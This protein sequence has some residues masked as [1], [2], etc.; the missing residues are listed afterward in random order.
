VRLLTNRSFGQSDRSS[1][2]V[3]KNTKIV[4][5][6]EIRDVLVEWDRVRTHLLT[7]R[8]KGFQL[9]IIGPDESEAIFT[10]GIY[11]QDPLRALSASLKCSAARA[12]ADDP[13][14][15]LQAKG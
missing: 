10:G 4:D 2:V 13:P 9:A 1:G 6:G 7:Q 14:L 3:V 12:L 5:L 15:A 8:A 11:K